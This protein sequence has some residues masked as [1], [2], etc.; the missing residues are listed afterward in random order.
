MTREIFDNRQAQDVDRRRLLLL[1]DDGRMERMLRRRLRQLHLTCENNAL[2]GIVRLGE[3]RFATV[4]LNAGRLEQQT[5]EA[6]KALR[7]IGPLSKILV[8]GEPFTEVYSRE[9]FLTGIA[10]IF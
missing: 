5:A 2:D 1:G 6:V 3:M 8:Y 7:R 9:A 4:L 10:K